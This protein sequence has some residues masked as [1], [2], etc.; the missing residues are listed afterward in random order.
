MSTL[1]AALREGMRKKTEFEH[2]RQEEASEGPG[3]GAGSWGPGTDPETAESQAVDRA[4]GLPLEEARVMEGDGVQKKY[5]DA[6]AA[7][8]RAREE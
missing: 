1:K 2:I 8:V 4:G 5:D 7:A 3:H 6:R